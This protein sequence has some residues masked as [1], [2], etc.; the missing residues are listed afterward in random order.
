MWVCT[1]GFHCSDS[2]DFCPEC[3][4]PKTTVIVEAEAAPKK[5]GKK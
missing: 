5:K 4:G 1:C 3:G 2:V